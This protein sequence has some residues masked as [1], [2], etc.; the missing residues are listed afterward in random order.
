M[1]SWWEK[2][3]K[4]ATLSLLGVISPIS[5]NP[6]VSWEISRMFSPYSP[7]LAGDGAGCQSGDCHTTAMVNGICYHTHEI[8]YVL[9]GWANRLCYDEFWL[10]KLSL[11]PNRFSRSRTIALVYWNAV[12]NIGKSGS[13]IGRVRWAGAG[14]DGVLV[15]RQYGSE[16]H[17]CS[18][19]TKPCAR[20]VVS[21]Q[22]GFTMKPGRLSSSKAGILIAHLSICLIYIIMAV[23]PFYDSSYQ[24]STEIYQPESSKVLTV[25]GILYP[26]AESLFSFLASTL[27][28]VFGGIYLLSLGPV[29][30]RR[31]LILL[32]L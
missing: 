4:C 28:F 22:V 6:F 3:R 25:N 24:K 1:S 26:S 16:Y 9:F 12:R 31:T 29:T 18:K 32:L 15:S 27:F 2:D 17:S 13:A 7:P 21:L 5:G 14:W 30:T 10:E 19:C 20:Q 11:Y 8:N 23:R